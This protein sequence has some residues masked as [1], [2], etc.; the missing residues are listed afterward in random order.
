MTRVRPLQGPEAPVL[1]RLLNWASRR[2]LGREAL[3]LKILAHNPRFLLPYLG[4]TRLVQGKTQL[5]PEIRILAMHLVAEIN[6]CAWCLDFG[7]FEA[8]KLGVAPDK[9]TAVGAYATDP[10]FSP[11]ERAALAYTSAA[12]QV[13]ARVD[14]ATFSQLRHHF[15]EREIVELTVAVAAENMFNRLNVPLEVESQGF[16]ALP[17]SVGRSRT[18]A[19]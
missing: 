15:S 10:R 6:H 11:A 7:Q 5:A 16:C 12:T 17:S 8:L 3:P 1:A 2:T 4:V 19:S 13:G 18:R 9:V 14:D